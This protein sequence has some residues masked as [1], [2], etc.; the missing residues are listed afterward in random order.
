MIKKILNK[1]KYWYWWHF[2]AT[3][4][5]KIQADMF[6]YGMVVTKNGKRI[7]PLKLFNK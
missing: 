6:Y 7:N 5:D 2:Q 4:I 3:T 1:I